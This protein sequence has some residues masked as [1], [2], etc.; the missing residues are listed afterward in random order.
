MLNNISNFFNLVK[1]RRV[2]KTLAPND[3]IAIGVRNPV[4]QS[5]FQPSAI[6]Y[7]D[8]ETQLGNAV[9]GNSVIGSLVGG[10]ILV[11][12]WVEGG[13]QKGLIASLTDLATSLPWTTAA[14]TGTAIGPTAQSSYDG[15]SN[16]SAIIAQTGAA[17]TTAYAAGIAKLHSGGGYNDWYLPSSWELNMCY[18]SAAVVNKVLGTNGFADVFNSQYWSSSEHGNSTTDIAWL[19]YFSSGNQSN[20]SKANSKGVRA[21]R[22]HTF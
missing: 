21:V 2:K 7:K 19:Q 20:D 4:T 11:A 12:V 16:T 13:V 8:L 14:F 22:T 15:S 17:P 9:I 5:N 6:F 3:M 10:G 1:G 18:T